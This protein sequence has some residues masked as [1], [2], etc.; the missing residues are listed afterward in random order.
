MMLYVKWHFIISFS[1]II[2]KNLI[3]NLNIPITDKL[4]KNPK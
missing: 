2:Q 1:E 3:K 4:K